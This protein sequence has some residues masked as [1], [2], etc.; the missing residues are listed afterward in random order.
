MAE[1]QGRNEE[2]R[3]IRH[4]SEIAHRFAEAVQADG[5]VFDSLRQDASKTHYLAMCKLLHH[6][7]EGFL[8]IA[9]LEEESR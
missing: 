7:S 6:A 9:Q 3:K 5:A 1:K 4:W 8:L 2:D